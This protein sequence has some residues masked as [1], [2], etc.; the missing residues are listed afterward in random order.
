[1]MEDLARRRLTRF[2][3]L[4]SVIFSQRSSDLKTN[5]GA[6]WKTYVGNSVPIE[7]NTEET[8]FG[9]PPVITRSNFNVSA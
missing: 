2:L 5:R 6:L 7:E 1:M 3:A 9:L 8:F 4:L